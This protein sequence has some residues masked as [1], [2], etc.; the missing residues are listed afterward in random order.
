M[1]GAEILACVP[2]IATLRSMRR[3]IG[4]DGDAFPADKKWLVLAA[5]GQA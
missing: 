4:F 5:D 3:E 2:F 1:A